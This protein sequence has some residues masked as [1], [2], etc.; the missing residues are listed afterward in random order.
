MR[1]VK[2]VSSFVLVF[3]ALLLIRLHFRSML[4]QINIA[5]GSITVKF[6]PAPIM[7]G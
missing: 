1:Q 3:A 4:K 5:A 2:M 6:S 7:G